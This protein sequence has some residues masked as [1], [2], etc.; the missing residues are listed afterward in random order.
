MLKILW[1]ILMSFILVISCILTPVDLAFPL[2]R[3]N[4]LS[5]NIFLYI[6]DF[7]FLIDIIVA[8]FSAFEDFDLKINDNLKDIAINYL[9]GW[10]FIDFISIFPI[11]LIFIYLDINIG[12][13][14]KVFRILRMGKLQKL[15]R[16]LKML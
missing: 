4:T 14:N 1:D 9:K 12:G 7:L 16:V 11:D 13:Y 15:A 5:Y 10:F 3:E 8:F 6:L 2:I